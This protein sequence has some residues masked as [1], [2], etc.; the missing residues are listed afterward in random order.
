MSW[1]N[2]IVAN[3]GWSDSYRGKRVKSTHGYVVEHGTGAEAYNF[4][5]VR[6]GLIYGYLRGASGLEALSDKLWTVVF[7]SKPTERARLRVVGWYE[8]AIVGG[9]QLRPEYGYDPHFPWVSDVERFSYSAVTKN[10]FVVPRN[11][12]ETII[13]PSGHRIKSTGIY[14]VAGAGPHGDNEIQ[15]IARKTMA[16]WLRRVL[17]PLRPSAQLRILPTIKPEQ[18]RGVIIDDGGVATGFTPLGEGE[19]HRSLREWTQANPTRVTG[20]AGIAEGDTERRL[21]SLDRVDVVYECGDDFWVVE[22][23]SRRSDDPDHY[24]GIFQCVKY[25]AVAAAMRRAGGG[26][27]R[28]ILVTDNPLS[29]EHAALACELDIAHY[30]APTER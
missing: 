14:Y 20:I 28:A 29:P 1:R 26:Q 5:P 3:I 15:D 22:V 4:K 25:R 10:A 8:R 21:D 2:I 30:L 7:I 11:D 9:Y 27:T 12:R 24:R 17:P 18:L 16:S 23:K 6:A 19:Y 13:L